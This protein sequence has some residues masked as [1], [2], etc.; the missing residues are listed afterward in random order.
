[1][2]RFISFFLISLAFTVSILP[3]DAHAGPSA[4]PSQV[5]AAPGAAASAPQEKY[6]SPPGHAKT[7]PANGHKIAKKRDQKL[8]RMMIVVTA[9]RMKTPLGEVG[10]AT[11]VV[12]DTKIQAQQMHD[13]TNALRE[14]PG[15]IV[16]QDGAPGT[17]A[18]VS[19]RGATPAQTLVMIDGV[20]LNDSTDGSFDLSNLMTDDLDRIEVVRGAG[21][22]LYGSQA[23]GGV[24]NMITKEGSGAPKF[25]LTSE[26]GNAGTQ[27]Q[28]A[29]A[30][31]ADGKLAYSG[32]ISYFSTNGFLQRNDGSDN[33]SG[34]GRLDYHLDPDTTIRAFA[35]YTAA[36]VGLATYS[37][38]AGIPINPVAH[39][40]TEFMLYKGEI[41]RRFG[42]K[43]TA[44]LS[45]YFVRDMLRIN[46]P[47]FSGL[48]IFEADHI[49]QET[50]GA[51]AQAIY[52]WSRDFR[53][54]AGFELRDRWAHSQS[55]YFFYKPPPTMQSL[56]MFN[57]HRDDF[58]GYIEQEAHFFRNHLIATGGF[59][60]D[61]NTQFGNEVSPSWAV[62]MP[63]PDQG[64]TFRGSYSEGFRAPDFDSLY[65]PGYGNPNLA[66]EISSEWDGGVT[67]DLG[68]G[69]EITANYFSRRVH[70]LIVAVPCAYNAATCPDGAHAG[71]AG[72]VDTQG[73]EFI[74]SA[75]PVKGLSLSGSFTYLDE[76]HVSSAADVQP[77]RVPK[78]SA[79]ALAEYTR[80]NL[81]RSEDSGTITVAYTF[82]G[83]RNDI[84]PQG[85]FANNSAYHRV[86][87][88]ASY[89]PGVAWGFVR[90]ATLFT[91]IN[92]LLDRHYQDALGFPAPTINYVAGMTFDF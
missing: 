4:A 65:F 57:A 82:V 61:G 48:D 56:T 8:P 10:T 54:L 30:D 72:R 37:I 59:R 62:A 6:E 67:K 46:A 20:P 16:T 60:V 83:D 32:A 13:V 71:N 26:G 70:N 89:T 29:T 28:V 66:P 15:V 76:T 2:W 43:L 63:F 49:A 34:A 55:D 39:Q 25:S 53:S 31:G 5:S 24:I 68:D 84:T 52:H 9:T 74:P 85:G 41:D 18:E 47:P 3:I 7:Q 12:T 44:S 51:I 92:N 17:L 77:T 78:Y 27:R 1:M 90:G 38:Y 23:I 91:R 75:H 40:R 58:S 35:R 45:G 19:I 87:L 33:L 86:D 22:S 64:L 14:V 80:A 42:E 69:V 88:A 21:G 81:L 11:S 79:Q 50:R 36:N 73:I